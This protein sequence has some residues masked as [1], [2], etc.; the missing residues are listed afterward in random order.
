MNEENI[1][2]IMLGLPGSGK[3]T[4]INNNV[5]LTKYYYISADAIRLSHPKY[6]PKHPEAIQDE[7]VRLAEQELYE[8]VNRKGNLVLDG[9]GINRKYTLNIIK[10][11]KANGY[12]VH[13]VFINTPVDICLDRN[14]SRITSNERFVPPSVIIDKAYSL[15]E[16]SKRLQAVAD[17]FVEVKYFTD[18][19]IF[20]DMDGVVAEY[21]DI[22]LD[23][24]GNINFVAYGIFKNAR[25]VMEVIDRLKV[26]SETKRLY[27][28]SASPN[29]ICSDEKTEW[30]KK[31]M[32]FIKSENI[33]YVG[34]KDFKSIMVKDLIKDL[35][36]ETRTCTLIDD[37][38]QIIEKA[39]K[40]GIHVMHPSKFLVE[41]EEIKHEI[42][43]LTI[44]TTIL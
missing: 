29:S 27:M 25:P 42:K 44:K 13:V 9:G 35:K 26:L 30:I 37:E 33:Y 36:L 7:C 21:Q 1:A 34:N 31:Y 39:R 4:Y 10:H 22:P 32:P 40:L 17:E 20:V 11:L 14:N 12:K 23:E 43:I 2:I 5:D 15:I 19:N 3:T 38:H 24:D 18:E 41:Y 28:L 16:S 6:D 8:K